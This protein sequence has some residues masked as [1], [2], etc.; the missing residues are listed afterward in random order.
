VSAPARRA[1]AALA[2]LIAIAPAGCLGGS[3]EEGPAAGGSTAHTSATGGLNVV[4]VVTD[5]QEPGSLRVMDTVRRELVARG[6]SFEYAYAT[7][8]Q[9][10]PSRAT[11]LTG[12]YAHNNGVRGN[13]PE[14][15]GYAHLDNSETIATWLD[16]AGY[17]TAWIG[18]F[19]N[20][21]GEPDKSQ[22]SG[23]AALTDVPEGWNRWWVPVDHTEAMMYGY[24]LNENG[25]VRRY[26]TSADDY[27]TD[28]LARKASGFVSEAARKQDPFLLVVAPTAPHK[29]S[30][31]RVGPSPAP[32]RDPRPAPRHQGAF[33]HEPLP[34]PPSFADT[35]LADQP[36]ARRL[37]AKYEGKPHGLEVPELRDGYRSRLESLLSVDDLVGRVL[38][39]LR[40]SGELD[41]TLVIFT[42]DQGFVLGEHGLVGKQLPYEESVRIPLVVRG[43]GIDAGREVEVPVANIDLAPTIVDAAN[44]SAG[45]EPDGIS[46]LPALRGARDLQPRSILLEG[47]EELPFAAVRTPSRQAYIETGRGE[48]ELYDLEADPYQRRNL[49]AMPRYAALRDRLAAKLDELRDCAGAVCR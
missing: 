46:L 3:D 14:L 33:S 34:R 47:F 12:Q 26:G 15:G 43:P 44:A 9:C 5:D 38:A 27:Q 16:E 10:C 28:V 41:R 29:E 8:P 24:A 31:T 19:L 18:K 25:T 42:S 23:E 11:L 45:L 30:D 36:L 49:A 17:E 39:E 13:E 4:I 6:T 2:G 32:A 21:Y 20:G 7:L 22:V 1:L 40:R 35:Q 37:V 48:V